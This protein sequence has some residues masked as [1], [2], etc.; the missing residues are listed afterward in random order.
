M[1]VYLDE[2]LCG[3]TNVCMCEQEAHIL[4]YA[5]GQSC[6]E[7]QKPAETHLMT[8]CFERTC[9]TANR[10]SETSVQDPAVIQMCLAGACT[11]LQVP[12]SELCKDYTASYWHQ[13]LLCLC[14]PCNSQLRRSCPG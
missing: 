9:A 2:Q 14:R 5:C 12:G 4:T 3:R 7:R 10:L 11:E 8:H 6:V 1:Y 13:Q